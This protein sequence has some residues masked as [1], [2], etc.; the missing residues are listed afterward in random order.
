MCD[1]LAIGV[2][3][4]VNEFCDFMETPLSSIA[5][6]YD[7]LGREVQNIASDIFSPQIGQIA[8]RIF[9]ALP[10][11]VTLLLLPKNISAGVVTALLVVGFIAP[12]MD[13]LMG[14]E[15]RQRMYRGVSDALFINAGSSL[16][17]LATTGNS[18]HLG[19]AIG[20]IF[21]SVLA[22]VYSEA[23]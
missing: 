5:E 11:T 13:N 7:Y 19:Q 1:V 21:S 4:A 15:M 8:R 6:S 12:A 17:S 3:N 9:N 22:F 23:N 2:K 20:S 14:K 16:L 18:V 10:F